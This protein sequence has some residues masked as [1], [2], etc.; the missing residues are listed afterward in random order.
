MRSS[1]SPPNPPPIPKQARMPE[2]DGLR[3]EC[4]L[5][6]II[7]VIGTGNIKPGKY[8]GDGIPNLVFPPG[9]IAADDF[10]FGHVKIPFTFEQLHLCSNRQRIF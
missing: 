9:V 1:P 7:V 10:F 6:E 4:E 2:L 5:V 3:F 8:A